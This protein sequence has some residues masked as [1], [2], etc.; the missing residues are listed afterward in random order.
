MPGFDSKR[1]VT[2]TDEQ[3]EDFMCGICLGILNDPFAAKCCKQLY[4]YDCINE[5]LTCSTTCPYDRSALRK[6]DLKSSDKVKEQMSSMPIRCEF[7]DCQTVVEL[8]HLNSHIDAC[9]YNP[10]RKCTTCGLTVGDINRHNCI[11]LLIAEKE[12]FRTENIELKSKL[13]QFKE[14]IFEVR[15]FSTYFCQQFTKFSLN[16][17]TF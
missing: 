10:E 17:I 11:E 2:I 4:C 8:K 13:N 12:K 14:R 9:I 6:E 1:F 7:D 15:I 3:R 5:W 16:F